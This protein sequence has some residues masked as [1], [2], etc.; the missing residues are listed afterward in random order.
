MSIVIEQEEPS[1]VHSSEHPFCSDPD[2]PCHN[3][4]SYEEYLEPSLNDGTMT[5]REALRMY[6][7]Q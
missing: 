3:Q 1:F 7:D 6:W 4:E 2:C 5:G